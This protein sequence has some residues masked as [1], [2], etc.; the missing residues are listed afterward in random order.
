V[1]DVEE[2]GEGGG[3]GALGCHGCGVTIADAV[4]IQE[5]YVY[6]SSQLWK[7]CGTKQ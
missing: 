2:G 5:M 3:Y 1:F 4:P 6:I 7:L